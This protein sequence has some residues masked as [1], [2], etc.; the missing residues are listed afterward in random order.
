MFLGK[1][2]SFQEF[3]AGPSTIDHQTQIFV[4]IIGIRQD[5]Q[6][7]EIRLFGIFICDQEND[8]VACTAYSNKF[9]QGLNG[10]FGGEEQHWRFSGASPFFDLSLLDVI[11]LLR[12]IEIKERVDAW[13]TSQ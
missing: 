6:I 13:V 10:K 4:E 8:I 9:D 1:D 7:F 5:Q 11:A 12:K 2:H 3:G